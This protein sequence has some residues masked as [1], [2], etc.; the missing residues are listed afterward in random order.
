M[1]CGYYPYCYTD[2]L[3]LNDVDINYDSPITYIH[4]KPESGMYE[5]TGHLVYESKMKGNN[6][7]VSLLGKLK[8]KFFDAQD[9]EGD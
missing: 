2:L 8:V 3:S 1:E 9:G 7:I 4:I 6:L 5:I